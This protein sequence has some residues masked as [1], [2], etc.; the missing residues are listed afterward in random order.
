MTKIACLY[1]YIIIKR[2]NGSPT[3]SRC[4]VG[5][6]ICHLWQYQTPATHHL[7]KLDVLITLPTLLSL[8]RA[9]VR[10]RAR[11]AHGAGRRGAGGRGGGA[12]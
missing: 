2:P 5:Y 1:I 3:Y 9:R 11:P 10:A 8:A 12:A 4:F 7:L 6:K